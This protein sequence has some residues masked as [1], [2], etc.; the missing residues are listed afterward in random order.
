VT[1]PADVTTEEL[2]ARVLAV[3]RWDKASPT[4]D[5]AK[6]GVSRHTK[7]VARYRAKIAGGGVE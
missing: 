4:P 1:D 3:G 2:V 7:M 5:E 6:A